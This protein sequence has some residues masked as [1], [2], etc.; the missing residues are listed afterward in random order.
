LVSGKL[1]DIVV[2]EALFIGILKCF[3]VKSQLF[4]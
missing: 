4:S 2:A 3:P 1:F